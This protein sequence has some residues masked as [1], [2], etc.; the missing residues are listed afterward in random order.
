MDEFRKLPIW[1]PGQYS[2][3]LKETILKKGNSITFDKVKF[4]ELLN[5]KKMKLSKYGLGFDLHKQHKT[6]AGKLKTDILNK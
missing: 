1:R 6:V 2:E 5:E 4:M 3:I